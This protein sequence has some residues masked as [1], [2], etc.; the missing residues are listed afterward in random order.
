MK[1]IKGWNKSKNKVIS[2]KHFNLGM[3][4]VIYHKKKMFL[5]KVTSNEKKINV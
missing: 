2:N 3:E 5:I 4:N 1:I